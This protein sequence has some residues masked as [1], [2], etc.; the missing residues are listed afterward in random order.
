MSVTIKVVDQHGKEV[1]LK[2]LTDQGRHHVRFLAN[3]LIEQLE[4]LD[5]VQE[6][7]V[8]WAATEETYTVQVL[9]DGTIVDEYN[10]GNSPRCSQTHVSAE[11]GVGLERMQAMA[12][13]TAEAMANDLDIPLDRVEEDEDLLT[14]LEGS[15]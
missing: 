4:E 7:A 13:Q 10:A 14:Q 8:V 6:K 1:E 15:T 9:I 3:Q 5:R 2:D 12:R 11:F